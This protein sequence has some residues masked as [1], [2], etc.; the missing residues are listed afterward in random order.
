MINDRVVPLD[1]LDPVYLD[2]GTFFGDGVYEVLRSYNGRIFALQEHLN[3]FQA[4]LQ[5][6]E[7]HSVDINQ[8]RSRIKTAFE[9]AQLLNAKIYFHVTRGSELR[10]H[11]FSENIKPSFFLF[12]TELKEDTKAKTSGITVSTHPDLR[13]KRCDIKSLNLLP[14]ILA[15]LDAEKKGCDE[16]ILV[17]DNG[18][19]TEGAGSAFFAVIAAKLYTAP[20]NAKILPSVTRKFVL[21]AAQ[22][23]NLPVVEQP[24]KISQAVSAEELFIAVTTRDIVPVVGFDDKTIGN[25]K[26]GKLT[27]MLIDQFH[28]FTQ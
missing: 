17:D 14:N 12:I 16:A 4:S 25:G 19:I 23:I 3:R 6:I 5:A 26:P 10:N 9:Q 20:L 13:W 28:S 15:R 27:K 11:L 7:I 8:V 1:D 22:N 24:I 21:K 2:R 18:F